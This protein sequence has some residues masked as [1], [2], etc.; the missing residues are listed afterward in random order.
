MA[1]IHACKVEEGFWL[2]STNEGPYPLHSEAELRYR[3]DEL[4]TRADAIQHTDDAYTR[5]LASWFGQGVFGTPWLMAKIGQLALTYLDISK[6]QTKRD[7]EMILS[8]PALAVLV[9][10]IDDRKAQVIAGRI[11]ERIALTATHLGIAIHPMSQVLEVPETKAELRDLLEVPEV[12]AEVANLSPDDPAYPQHT[13]RMGYA[14]P[15][16]G[17]TPRRPLEDVLV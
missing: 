1:Q 8:A 5:E 11:F 17:H 9:S 6:G 2:F 10:G 7:S 14:K 3:I 12:K 16:E 4:I 15:E 13:F